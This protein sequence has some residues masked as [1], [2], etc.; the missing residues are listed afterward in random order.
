MT[1][2]GSIQVSR[3]IPASASTIFA[4]LRNPVMH[5]HIDGSGMITA[6]LTKEI[7]KQVGDKFTIAMNRVGDDYLMI[8]IVVNFEL[9]RAI[10]WAPAPGDTSRSEGN[11][12]ENIGKPAGYTWGYKL[13][14]IDEKN[15]KVT[16][17]FHY[18]PLSEKNFE[19]G[20][21]W[22]N[23]KNTVQESMEKTLEL[24]EGLVTK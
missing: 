10:F 17:V 5:Q 22:I 3:D 13:E 7:I 11:K 6:S 21:K 9:D 4:I 15:T 18:G 8:N 14:K 23:T 1:S 20:G 24:L 16:E 19:D 12:E 2:K